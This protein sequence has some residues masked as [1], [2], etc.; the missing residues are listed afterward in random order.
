MHAMRSAS[1]AI[2]IPRYQD[3][4]SEPVEVRETDHYK[5]EYIHSLVEK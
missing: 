2:L 4:G 3:Y 5:A 1:A